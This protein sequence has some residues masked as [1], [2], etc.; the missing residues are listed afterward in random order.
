M[1]NCPLAECLNPPHDVPPSKVSG[2]AAAHFNSAT[3]GVP[4]QHYTLH[5]RVVPPR[6]LSMGE[7][8]GGLGD[9]PPKFEVGTAH[10][11]V[12]PI[13]C[14]LRISVIWKRCENTKRKKPNFSFVK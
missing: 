1:L 10:A 7:D 3:G 13:F 11:S 4:L 14:I 2:S 8:L 12:P 9:G 6:L 5:N